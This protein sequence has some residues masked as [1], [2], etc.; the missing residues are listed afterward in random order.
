MSKVAISAELEVDIP[1]SKVTA[2]VKHVSDA[3]GADRTAEFIQH[4]KTNKLPISSQSEIE[5]AVVEYT[6]AYASSLP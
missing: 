1:N 2:R 5:H 6:R 3:M 4:C